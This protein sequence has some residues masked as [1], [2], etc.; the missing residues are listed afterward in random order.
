MKSFGR[1][2]EIQLPKRVQQSLSA[3]FLFNFD[4]QIS[5]VDRFEQL[6]LCGSLLQNIR[7]TLSK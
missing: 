7:S 5:C 6:I 4:E 3:L 1:N 2:S